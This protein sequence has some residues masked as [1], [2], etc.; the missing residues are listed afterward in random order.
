[1]SK[2]LIAAIAS[3]SSL[4]SI[5]AAEP[6]AEQLKTRAAELDK[7]LAGQGFTVVIEAP[8]VV[9]GDEGAAKVKQRAA[10]FL[11]WT[12]GLIEKDFFAKR[13]DKII[14]VW[15]FKNERTY[16]KGAKK[17]FNDEP[18]TPYGYYTTEFD[19]LV[20]NIGP[21][22]GTLSHEL[23]H[24][25]VEANFP[26]APSWFNEGLAS[27]YERPT[28]KR[29]HI[30]GLPNWRLPSLQRQIR[31]KSLPSI[32]TM[33]RTN[34]DEFYQAS[35]DSYAFARYLLLYLQE[36][37]KLRDFYA[38]FVADPKDLTGKSALEAILGEPLATFEPK[39]RKWALAL[40]EN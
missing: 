26:S 37:G 6:T 33:L 22:A 31:A 4:W 3:L 21:G 18:D 28:E 15:L 34:R 25:Y 17:F 24:P 16:R 1:M 39:W 40:E 9:V 2:M 20:M 36:Q 30:I 14:E 7:K 32:E 12:V 27:L 13:P 35:Y 19:A 23:V 11:R 10:G 29:G 5:A 8:F 38:K